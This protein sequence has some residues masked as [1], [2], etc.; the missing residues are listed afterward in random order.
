MDHKELIRLRAPASVSLAFVIWRRTQKDAK[1]VTAVQY[2]VRVAAGSDY[3]A[4]RL[5][6]RKVQSWNGLY[7]E[8]TL[9]DRE[10]REP[11]GAYGKHL[12]D[13]RPLLNGEGFRQRIASLFRGVDLGQLNV[14][15]TVYGLTHTHTGHIDPVRFG[16]VT[17]LCGEALLDN[18]D[19]RLIV[20]PTLQTYTRNKLLP[21]FKHRQRIGEERRRKGWELSFS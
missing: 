3:S 12:Q 6:T 4:S 19:A 20:F 13:M 2:K 5:T 15:M 8:L 10:V 14:L 9:T 21:N 16:K 1:L 17:E 11:L 18:G 7:T